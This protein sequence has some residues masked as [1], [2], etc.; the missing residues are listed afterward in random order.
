MSKF[1]INLKLQG[2][3]LNIEGEKSDIPA[4]SSAIK[5]QLSAIVPAIPLITESPT[6]E[7]EAP[8]KPEASLMPKPRKKRKSTGVP[9]D[10]E[11]KPVVIIPD[12]TRF[13]VPSQDWTVGQKTQ[14]LLYVVEQLN[15]VKDMSIGEITKTFNEY[16]REAKLLTPA[17]VSRDL[18]SSKTT[19]PALAGVQGDKWFLTAE[20]KTAAQALVNQALG[21]KSP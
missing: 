20:G 1:K 4:I 16:F 2:L 7:V 9:T 3:E 14:W 18:N 17:N 8:V 12:A 5:Q 15:G 19:N 11:T 10:D 6:L 21:T 13:G